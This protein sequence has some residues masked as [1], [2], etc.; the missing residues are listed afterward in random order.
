[1]CTREQEYWMQPTLSELEER[2]DPGV[3]FRISRAAMVNLNWIDEVVPLV[4]GYGEVALKN[5][6]RLEV[7]RRRMKELVQALE[8]N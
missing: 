3:F 7:S 6:T 2:V 8:G 1:L 5:G 4:G